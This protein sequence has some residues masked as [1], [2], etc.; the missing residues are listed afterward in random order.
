M[1]NL[2]GV[3]PVGRDDRGRLGAAW[4]IGGRKL[5]RRVKIEVGFLARIGRLATTGRAGR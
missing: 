5:S 2:W 1:P 3:S 4:T